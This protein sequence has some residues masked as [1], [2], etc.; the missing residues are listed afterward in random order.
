MV[1]SRGSRRTARIA[2]IVFSIVGLLLLGL[3]GSFALPQNPVRIRLHCDRADGQCVFEQDFHHEIRRRPF[4]VGALG[5]ASVVRTHAMRGGGRSS[6]SFNVGVRRYFY[7]SYALPGSAAKAAATINAFVANPAQPRLEII[8]DDRALTRLAWSLLALAALA[9]VG[10]SVFSW[11][12][13]SL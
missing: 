13:L 8:E 10:V 1:L 12:K 9:I 2:L 11:R 7:A 4:R 6:V 3:I 5:A